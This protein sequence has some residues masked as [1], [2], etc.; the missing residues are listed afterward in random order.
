MTGVFNNVLEAIGHTPIIKLNSCVP[1]NGHHFFAKVEY[2]NP[3]GSVK[4]RVALAIIEDA[5]K[6]GALKPGGTIVEATSGNTG[7]GLAMVAAL[8][9]YKCIFVMPDKISEEKRATLRAYG[10]RVVI[11]PTN[12]EPEDPR[13]FYSVARKFVE[14]TPKSFY[15]NQYHN[16]ANPIKHYQMTG[17]EIW[18]QMKGKV[19]AFVG[20]AGTGGTLSGVGK[21]LKEKNPNVKIVCAD[22]FGSILHDLFYHKEVREKPHSYLVEGIGEDMLPENVHFNVMDDFI[23]VTDAETFQITREISRR[24]GLLAGPSCGT[25]LTAAIK[26]SATGK[27]KPDANIV[28]LFPD[29]GRSY[30]SKAFNEE[31]IREKGLAASLLATSTVRTLLDFTKTKGHQQHLPRLQVETTILD[32]VK[33]VKDQG[34][35][36][37]LAYSGESVIGLVNVADILL[38]LATGKLRPDEPIL[39]LVKSSMPEVNPETKLMDVELMLLDAPFVL[40]KEANRVI[41]RGD[42]ADFMSS[43]T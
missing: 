23:R 17:P 15:A 24:E 31:W 4:D 27:L 35:N 41:S 1:Q 10:A 43:L 13:S 14:I 40:V 32:A 5:E 33:V 20:G 39:H 3:G 29:G 8:K 19:D 38:V 28:V 16:P 7:V 30:L 37:I 36:Q 26:Y 12:V 6:S 21:Y 18:E 2:F 42:L 11:T 22:P 25:A 34:L 9:G